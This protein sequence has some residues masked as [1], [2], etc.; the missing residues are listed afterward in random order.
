[1]PIA[2][3]EAKKAEELAPYIEAALARRET[4]APLRDD[5][6]AIVPASR[7]KPAA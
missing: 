7:P 6:I 3:D 2:I 5:E 4:R 1:M